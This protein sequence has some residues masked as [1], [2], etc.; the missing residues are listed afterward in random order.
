MKP[1]EDDY[2]NIPGKTL[3]ELKIEMAKI[4]AKSRKDI[5]YL[6]HLKEIVNRFFNNKPVDPPVPL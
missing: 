2:N 4:E 1:K 3:K 6:L 5:E